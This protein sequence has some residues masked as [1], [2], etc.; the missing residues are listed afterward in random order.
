MLLPEGDA[1]SAGPMDVHAG[2]AVVTLHPGDVVCAERGVRLETLLGSCVAIIL[3]DPARTVGAMCHIVHRGPADGQPWPATIARASLTG[4][5]A[6]QAMRAQLAGRGIE[7]RRCHAYVYGGGNM[8]PDLVQ[9]R[10]VGDAN[11]SWALDALAQEGVVVLHHD[12]GGRCYRR[13]AWTVG[14]EEPVVTAVAV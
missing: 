7:A 12:L 9:Q 4:T 5:G 10:H 1:M 11:A 3:T 13:L 2:C 14:P 8:F 6:L